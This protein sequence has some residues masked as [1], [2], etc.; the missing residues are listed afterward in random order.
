MSRCGVNEFA[1]DIDKRMAAMEADINRRIAEV[2]VR[3]E[4]MEG[5]FNLA[6]WIQGQTIVCVV[7]PLV[8]TFLG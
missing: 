2:D 8:R 5:R 3:F 1:R 6:Y 4:R 7:I